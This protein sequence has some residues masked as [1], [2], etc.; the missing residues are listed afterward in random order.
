MHDQKRSAGIPVT[1]PHYSHKILK[2]CSKC[3]S[4]TAPPTCNLQKQASTVL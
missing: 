4:A 1:G 2:W 3:L